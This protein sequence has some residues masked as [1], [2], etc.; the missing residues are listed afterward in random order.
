MAAGAHGSNRSGDREVIRICR[1][2]PQRILRLALAAL[3]LYAAVH[4]IPD[5]GAFADDI[6]NFRLL[7]WWALNAVAIVLPWIEL[8]GAL[9]LGAGLWVPEMAWLLGALSA[10]YEVAG[11]SAVVR[12]I[13]IE[14]GCF[15]AGYQG[16][17]WTVIVVNAFVLVAVG[18]I[19]V[20]SR[21]A[22]KSGTDLA[23]D[24]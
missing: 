22:A 12:G 4:K 9:L 13:D 16:S 10:V 21:Q 14:C 20:W 24:L 3:F 15:G 19:L 17:A 11:L 7:P 6:D 23:P 8:L 5:P 1:R 18:M 2:W